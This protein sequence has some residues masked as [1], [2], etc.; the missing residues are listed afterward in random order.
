MPK[1][2]DLAYVV[3]QAPD[4][5]QMERFMNDFG[6]LTAEKTN[7]ALFLRGGGAAAAIHITYKGDKKFIGAGFVV[8]SREDLDKL[9]RLDGSGPVEEIVDI[10]GGGWRVRMRH[11]DGLQIDAVWGQT[12]VGAIARRPSGAFNWGDRK[13][14]LNQSLRPK[15][16]PG[17]ALRLGHVVLKV[18]NHDETLKWMKDRFG[19]LESDTMVL[20]ENNKV[21]GTFIRFNLGD[22][23]VDHHSILI[24]EASEVGCHH[25][26]FEMQDFDAVMGAHD[27]LTRKGYLLDIG[28]GRHLVGS[29]IFDYWNDPFGNRVEHYTDGD[30]NNTDY[31][32]KDYL[33]SGDGPNKSQWGMD[34]TPQF[35]R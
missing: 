11:P 30:V 9:A 2:I 12:P 32:G 18:S 26:A 3:Y 16:E 25:C 5:D 24:N 19:M 10:P 23:P 6:L 34:P 27:Y 35:F 33:L 7:D 28:V 13:E 15:R 31:K 14:R 1:A 21:V 20:P 17:L 22:E 29:Q 8:R 4:L